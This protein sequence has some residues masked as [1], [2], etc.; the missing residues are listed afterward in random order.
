M[1]VA[2]AGGAGVIGERGGVGED[3][4]LRGAPSVR[5]VPP[6]APKSLPYYLSPSLTVAT[7][8]SRGKALKT[9]GIRWLR[10][11]ATLSGWLRSHPRACVPGRA[12]R[13]LGTSRWMGSPTRRARMA[14]RPARDRVCA[15]EAII[16]P[17]MAKGA[18]VRGTRL[19]PSSGRLGGWAAGR[20]RTSRG[21][22]G[23]PGVGGADRGGGGGGVGE[24]L[25]L[26]RGPLGGGGS[27][28]L[29]LLAILLSPTITVASVAQ[30]T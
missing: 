1:R 16:T 8:A 28:L 6:K 30:M 25:G 10:S 23:G 5:G 2:G 22:A 7:V 29:A 9:L 27:S 3:L 13:T 12:Y 26:R 18:A 21:R 14:R 24:D 4:G 15:R 20:V 11:A 19:R 17:T